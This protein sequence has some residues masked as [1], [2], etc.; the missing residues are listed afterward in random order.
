MSTQWPGSLFACEWCCYTVVDPVL[1]AKVNLISNSVL[2]YTVLYCT[3]LYYTSR[4]VDVKEVLLLHCLPSYMPL[5]RS[6]EIEHVSI[7]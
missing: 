1:M 4:V 7:I 2:Y 5:Y 6:K 3:I